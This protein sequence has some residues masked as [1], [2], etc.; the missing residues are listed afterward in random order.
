MKKII[1]GLTLAAMV[2]PIATTAK[3]IDLTIRPNFGYRHLEGGGNQ[4]VLG[5]SVEVIL[6]RLTNGYMSVKP[7]FEVSILDG[8]TIFNI[9]IPIAGRYPLGDFTPFAHLGIAIGHGKFN[10]VSDT[11]VAF[12]IGGGCDFKVAPGFTVGPQIELYVFDATAFDFEAV[13][14]FYL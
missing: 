5:G 11:D 4:L 3:D 2:L 10:N 6:S 7:G 13:A 1:L 12:M 14:S 8:V 9:N